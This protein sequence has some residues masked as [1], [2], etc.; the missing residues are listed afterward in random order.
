MQ[1]YSSLIFHRDCDL[2]IALS[3]ALGNATN[4]AASTSLIEEPPTTSEEEY[5]D[6]AAGLLN[7]RLQKYGKFFN[8]EV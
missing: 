8:S 5:L 3:T 2:I 7:N 6:I 1:A 4:H